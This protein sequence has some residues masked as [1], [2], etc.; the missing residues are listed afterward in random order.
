MS[1]LQRDFPGVE[2]RPKLIHQDSPQY[3]P[4]SR[5]RP[6]SSPSSN[7]E[8]SPRSSSL[9][10]W[11]GKYNY[12]RAPPSNYA[13]RPVSPLYN[14]SPGKHRRTLTITGANALPVRSME[15]DPLTVQV[16]F[17]HDYSVPFHCLT[18][19]YQNPK[20]RKIEKDVIAHLEKIASTHNPSSLAPLPIAKSPD[21]G[22][23]GSDPE[24]TLAVTRGL[25]GDSPVPQLLTLIQCVPFLASN[26]LHMLTSARIS[27]IVK[28]QRRGQESREEYDDECIKHDAFQ[29]I[30]AK[31]VPRDE[32][33]RRVA[34][35]SAIGDVLGGAAARAA[36]LETL[37]GIQARKVKIEG[38]LKQDLDELNTLWEK[39]WERLCKAVDRRVAKAAEKRFENISGSDKPP[40]SSGSG[41][42]SVSTMVDGKDGTTRKSRKVSFED[43][44]ST[45]GK[46]TEVRRQFEERITALER[47]FG[48]KNWARASRV[49]ALEKQNID[50]S[51][52]IRS[53]ICLEIIV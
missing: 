39:L 22:Q 15:P 37:E 38:L 1:F 31:L 25:S 51:V 8:Y 34:S 42:V 23:T 12:S 7:F 28:I 35:S 26:Y 16:C 5:K 4:P 47:K 33:N 36:V 9:R 50:V 17:V 11:S 40:T 41:I 29:A 52:N 13:V 44:R 6:R 10:S 43:E 24:N 20:P 32:S 2:P 46:E 45:F 48:E 19:D 30:A 49:A 27:E 14:P 53:I 21:L 18:G 3:L